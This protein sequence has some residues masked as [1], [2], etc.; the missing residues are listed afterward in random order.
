[1]LQY[2]KVGKFKSFH[3]GS[4]HII[5]LKQLSDNDAEEEACN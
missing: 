2:L 3:S 4:Y 1:M 5:Q